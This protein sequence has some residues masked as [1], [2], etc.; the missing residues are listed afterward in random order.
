MECFRL[1][2]EAS[3]IVYNDDDSINQD[4]KTIIKDGGQLSLLTLF[5]KGEYDVKSLTL[6]YDRFTEIRESLTEASVKMQLRAMVM[7]IELDFFM[8][9]AK[10]IR[11]D[12]NTASSKQSFA[13]DLIERE[14]QHDLDSLNGIQDM[15]AQFVRHNNMKYESLKNVEKSVYEGVFMGVFFGCVH[16]QKSI[17]VW[18]YN[19][20]ER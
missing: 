15:Q 12:G 1:L 17:N 10:K 16:L 2:Q 5:N 14:M 19:G 3:G 11:G 8:N 4:K 18:N 20:E 9:Q 6:N 7:Q 13:L